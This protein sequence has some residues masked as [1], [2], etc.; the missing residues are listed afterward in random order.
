MAFIFK[1]H[2]PRI[3]M[4]MAKG[5]KKLSRW[6]NTATFAKSSNGYWLAWHNDD[7]LDKVAFLTPDHPDSEPCRWLESW[8]KDDTIQTTIN[9]F[10]S[11]EFES[12]EV[13]YPGGFVFNRQILNPETGEWE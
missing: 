1:G 6:L 9:Y 12:D 8:D 13:E 4:K 10:E 7:F 11:G 2:R 5:D 3:A